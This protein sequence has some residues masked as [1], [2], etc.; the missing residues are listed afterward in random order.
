MPKWTKQDF[1]RVMQVVDAHLP[2][3][4]QGEAKVYGCWSGGGRGVKNS[5]NGY[6][7]PDV[8]EVYIKSDAGDRIAVRRVL[9]HQ[10]RTGGRG[11]IDKE[12]GRTIE[13]IKRGLG[14]PKL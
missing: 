9:S 5:G 14:R 12:A 11:W 10:D 3:D 1:R 6:G 8:G 7:P 13:A 4:K 2:L